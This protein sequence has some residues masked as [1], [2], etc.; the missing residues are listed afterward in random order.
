MTTDVSTMTDAALN[1]AAAKARGWK[2]ADREACGWGKGPPVWITG[3]E[4]NPTYQDYTPA[5]DRAAAM[6]L[7]EIPGWWDRMDPLKSVAGHGAVYGVRHHYAGYRLA[8]VYHPSLPRA[9]TEAFV[10]A[11][12]GGA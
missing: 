4:R 9:I 1:I 12:G 8:W 5:T 7:L 2:L 10:A 3:D 11:K 6:E